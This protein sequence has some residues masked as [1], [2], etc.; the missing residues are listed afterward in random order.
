MLGGMTMRRGVPYAEPEIGR[1]RDYLK[2]LGLSEYDVRAYVA[3][4][5]AGPSKVTDLVRLAQVPQKRIY[6]V[7]AHLDDLRLVEKE[8]QKGG[9]Y[10][11]TGA[12]ALRALTDARKAEVLSVAEELE[13]GSH[14]VMPLVKALHREDE[15]QPL[16]FVEMLVGADQYA[17][18]HNE[19]LRNTSKEL[20]SFTKPPF[21]LPPDPK[22][23][24]VDLLQRS[25][26]VRCIYEWGVSGPVSEAHRLT[27]IGGLDAFAEAG[28]EAR[29]APVLPLKMLIFDRRAVLLILP[30]P[31]SGNLLPSALLVRHPV[32]ADTQARL[33]ETYWTDARPV[34][35]AIRRKLLRELTDLAGTLPD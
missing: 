28:E 16:D 23:N 14:D 35:A 20:L 22:V 24:G 9:T 18:V 2:R 21:L 10:R 19:L 7:L 26:Q 17:L 31:H 34:T 32:F 1:I 30:D 3:L 5:Q 12:R 27:L 25:V 29:V 13:R 6:Q 33:F 4:L 15:E 11:A 8:G